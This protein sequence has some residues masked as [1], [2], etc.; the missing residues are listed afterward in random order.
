MLA[1]V[2][3]EWM[4]DTADTFG[5]AFDEASSAQVS[6][7]RAKVLLFLARELRRASRTLR[8][9][10]RSEIANGL[11]AKTFVAEYDPV[12]S[13]LDHL[14]TTIRG[15]GKR[16]P[17]KVKSPLGRK[18]LFRVARIEDEVVETRDYV[19][20]FLHRAKT[21]L[22]PFDQ[23]S[24][25]RGREDAAAGRVEDV[26]AIIERLQHG[27]SHGRQDRKSVV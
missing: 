24:L 5:R 3:P 22:R 27:S 20:K 11:E 7:R 25:R 1:E 26:Q 23:E 14:L 18:L 21:P 4:K 9:V 2:I 12:I 15:I 6:D 17:E 13:S 16:I 10:V 19:A 8:A